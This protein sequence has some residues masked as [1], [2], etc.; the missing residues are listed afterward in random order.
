MPATAGAVVDVADRLFAAIEEGDKATVDRM[1]S[2]DIAVWG[3]AYTARELRPEVVRNFRVPD[4]GSWK[5]IRLQG[6]MPLFVKRVSLRI[7]IRMVRFW[8]STIDVQIRSG[9]GL[10]MTGTASVATTSAGL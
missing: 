6:N 5:R 7:C 8:R 3:I 4:D 10:P 1:W 9:S 2:D